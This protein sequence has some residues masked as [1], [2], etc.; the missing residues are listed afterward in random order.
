M[1]SL[2]V[3]ILFAKHNFETKVARFHIKTIYHFKRKANARLKI[4][5][6]CQ[7]MFLIKLQLQIASAAD[8]ALQQLQLVA[9]NRSDKDQ[10]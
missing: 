7:H 6:Q 9:I 1:P 8:R 2:K 10:L 4:V 3:R 5:S